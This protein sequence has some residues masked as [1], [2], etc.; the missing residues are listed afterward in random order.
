MNNA[1][2][3]FNDLYILYEMNILRVEY[4]LK[5][6]YMFGPNYFMVFASYIII[7]GDK[8]GL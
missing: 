2:T 1:I 3:Y 5:S 8:Y 4:L 6:H 7:S